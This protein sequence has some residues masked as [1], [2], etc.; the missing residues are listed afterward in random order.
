MTSEYEWNPLTDARIP[1]AAAPYFLSL[2]REAFSL[3]AM[4]LEAGVLQLELGVL[5][6]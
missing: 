5:G 3:I 4:G 2:L 6:S 1:T